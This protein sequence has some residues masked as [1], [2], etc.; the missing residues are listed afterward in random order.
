MFKRIL[1]PVDPA[2]PFGAANEYAV[3]LAKKFQSSIVATYIID[4]QLI[5]GHVGDQAA[6]ALDD[7]L[8]W[9][10]R[11][12]MDDFAKHH[13][14]L[15]V[16]KTL[17]YGPTHTAIFQM[18]LQTG[19]DLVVVGGYHNVAH[20]HV[21]GS[22]VLDIVQ[23]DE[24]PTFVVRRDS[25]L[26]GEKDTIVV[27]FDGSQRPLENLL[28]VTRFAKA[29]GATIDLVLVASKRQ[30]DKAEHTLQKGRILV[31]EQGVAARTHV[32]RPNLLAGKGRAILKHARRTGSPLIAVSRL[33]RTSIHTGRSRTVAWLVAHSDVPVWVVRR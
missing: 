29:L 23:H 27:P 20:P 33:G 2:R 5:G 17:I 30:Q 12:A 16:S 21:W 28:K 4:E 8:E 1:I 9:V 32:L 14:D 7:A 3:A 11:D 18:V 26:P 13:E 31:E 24:R 19:A 6:G 10:G 25:G 22:T 15:A